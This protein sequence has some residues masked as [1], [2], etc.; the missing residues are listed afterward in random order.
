MTPVMS[1]E[2]VSS[3]RVSVSYKKG[4]IHYKQFQVHGTLGLHHVSD[5]IRVHH[6]SIGMHWVLAVVSGYLCDFP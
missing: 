3:T 4:S 1:H 5:F 6:G 2:K